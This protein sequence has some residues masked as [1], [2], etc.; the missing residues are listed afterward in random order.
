MVPLGCRRVVA[1]LAV[2][3][4]GVGHVDAKARDAAPVPV[5]QD[6]V[7]GAP[8]LLVPPVEVGLGG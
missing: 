4:Q 7:E 6:L 2:L 1:Q 3:D 8:D 5:A